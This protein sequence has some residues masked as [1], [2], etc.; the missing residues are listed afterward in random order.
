M[1]S[2][3]VSLW[4][5]WKFTWL[6]PYPTR[7]A[8][9]DKRKGCAPQ[10]LINKGNTVPS[11]VIKLNADS[12]RWNFYLSD[13]IR[14][15]CVENNVMYNRRLNM[16]GWPN[17]NGVLSLMIQGRQV[18]LLNLGT[19]CGLSSKSAVDTRCV[20]FGASCLKIPVTDVKLKRFIYISMYFCIRSL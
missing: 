8:R 14:H 19:S 13:C 9:I 6:I 10:S 12:S 20:V 1:A 4:V 11:V 15:V 5:H 18:C 3:I 7:R 17:L 16:P 2:F